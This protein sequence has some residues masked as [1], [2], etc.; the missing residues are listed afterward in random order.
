MLQ[1]RRHRGH[2][3]VLDIAVYEDTKIRGMGGRED[4]A[5]T[6]LV[7]QLRDEGR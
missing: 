4:R 1:Q 6:S 3:L 2:L 5:D 7:A